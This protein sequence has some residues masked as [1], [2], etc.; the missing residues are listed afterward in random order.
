MVAR[1]V[2]LTEN[3]YQQGISILRTDDGTAPEQAFTDLLT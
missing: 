2:R 1:M 3:Q